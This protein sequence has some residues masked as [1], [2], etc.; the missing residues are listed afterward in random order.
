MMNMDRWTRIDAMICYFRLLLKNKYISHKI[1]M[2]KWSYSTNKKL[3]N[4]AGQGIYIHRFADRE[5]WHNLF[6]DKSIIFHT[7][8]HK[9]KGG[10]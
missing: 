2:N 5:I 9:H 7:G 10:V 6:V 3:L 8:T 1:S 4:D